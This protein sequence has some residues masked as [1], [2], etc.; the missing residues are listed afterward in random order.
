MK[1][2]DTWFSRCIAKILADPTEI[3][4]KGENLEDSVLSESSVKGQREETESEDQEEPEIPD[5]N[6]KR[7]Y[8]WLS[9]RYYPLPRFIWDY[10]IFCD[11]NNRIIVEDNTQQDF[12]KLIFDDFAFG[13]EE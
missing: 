11:M 1:G 2:K 8:K 4:T 10:L 7:R 5:P 6:A 13:H 3:M 9:F 12:L